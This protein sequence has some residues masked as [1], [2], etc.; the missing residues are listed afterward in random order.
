M[1]PSHLGRTLKRQTGLG[2]REWRRLFRLRRALCQLRGPGQYVSQVAY[3]LGFEHPT[4]F[5]R[6]FRTH[7]GFAPRLVRSLVSA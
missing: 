1:S 5:A 4:Q 2:F 6:E 7:F 3:D